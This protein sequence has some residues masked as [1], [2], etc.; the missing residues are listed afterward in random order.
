[1]FAP[2]STIHSPI[3]HAALNS[4]Y[5]YNFLHIASRYNHFENTIKLQ[6]MLHIM[7]SFYTR[8]Y[9]SSRITRCSFAAC[10]RMNR[11]FSYLKL[12]RERFYSSV[13]CFH[14]KYGAA[15]IQDR[16]QDRSH[17]GRNKP[18]IAKNEYSDKRCSTIF[19][20]RHLLKHQNQKIKVQIFC[21]ILSIFVWNL[22]KGGS[23]IYQRINTFTN[24]CM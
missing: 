22:E 10:S 12:S 15:I 3:I 8:A 1:M 17:V 21:Y 7:I 4:N 24:K 14:C 11:L 5:N 9:V 16:P 13:E 20:Y 2:A 23:I 18:T 6:I 19:K